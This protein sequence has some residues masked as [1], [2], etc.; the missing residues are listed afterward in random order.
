MLLS[1]LRWLRGTEWV[2][3]LL[4]RLNFNQLRFSIALYKHLKYRQICKHC[5]L[6]E[7]GLGTSKHVILVEMTHG[8]QN[9]PPE[10][11]LSGWGGNTTLHISEFSLW[12]VISHPATR[13]SFLLRETYP[14][15][16][17]SLS[18]FVSN[19]LYSKKRKDRVTVKSPTLVPASALL[20]KLCQERSCR[21]YPLKPFYCCF[22]WYQ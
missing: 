15:P 14:L 4:N 3:H 1:V 18:Y 8:N 6:R 12:S 22:L 2:S 20:G 7:Q 17:D 5:A 11:S 9:H 13:L 19:C 16:V 21:N 10:L